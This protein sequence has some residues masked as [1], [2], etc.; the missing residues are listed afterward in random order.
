MD[1]KTVLER[2]IALAGVFTPAAPVD[3]KDLFAGRVPQTSDVVD[4]VSQR[5]QHAIIFGERGV[6]KTSLANVVS[7]FLEEAGKKVLAPRVNCDAGDSYDS[8]WRKVFD[9]VVISR[10]AKKL[11]FGTTG[12]EKAEESLS[13]TLP[14][15]ITPDDVRACLVQLGTGCLLIVIIDEFDRLPDGRTSRLFADTIKTLSDQAVPATLVL[16][17]VAD[18]IADLIHEHQSVERA[19]VQIRMPR[20]SQRELE[21]IV[22]K[23]LARVEM[24]ADEPARKRIATLS[25]GF[26]HYTHLLALHAARRAIDRNS[27]S[28]A[29]EDVEGALPTA[30]EKTQQSIL[31]AYTRAIASPRRENLY[32]RALLAC[33]LA[34]KDDLGFFSPSDVRDPMSAIMGRRYEIASF[35]RHLNDFSSDSH[36][37]ILQRTGAPRK[38]RY[39]FSNPLMQPYIVIQGLSGGL[40]SAGFLEKIGP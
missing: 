30:I 13:S 28:V 23:G 18:N 40:V 35:V 9:Q 31:D 22:V 26:P 5:G 24:T 6:G 29:T 34:R 3:E 37:R 7:S 2:R 1:P 20:M 10:R 12:E 15:E 36:G 27:A 11:G 32:P 38:Y 39:R 19:L 17:G 4:A 33:A 16:V 8:V 25:Q 14:A 21:E